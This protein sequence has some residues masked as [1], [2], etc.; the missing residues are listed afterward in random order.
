M[1]MYP[2]GA[3]S[4]C[5]LAVEYPNDADFSALAPFMRMHMKDGTCNCGGT[6][7]KWSNLP[8]VIPPEPEVDYEELERNMYDW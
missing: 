6:F 4:R 7:D 2:R 5:G 1:S 3:C 8:A